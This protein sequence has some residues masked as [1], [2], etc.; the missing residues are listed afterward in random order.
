VQLPHTLQRQALQHRGERGAAVAFVGPQVV[1]VE[2]DAAAGGL[3]DCGEVLAVVQFVGA[4]PQV[5]D[6]GLERHRPPR[7][8]TEPRDVARRHRD[9][10]AALPRR[11][12]ERGLLDA[13]RAGD[14]V[15]REVLAD[16]GGVQRVDAVRECRLPRQRVVDAPAQRLA[17]AVHQLGLRMRRDTR[18][19]G[20]R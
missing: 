14:A 15:E 1:Q 9:A 10:G 6:A 18:E 13:V 5:V 12:Q 11:Q 3:R 17:D 7:Q 2:H 20:P 16:P 19:Q 4:R 8:R